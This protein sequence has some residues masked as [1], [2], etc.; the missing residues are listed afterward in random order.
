MRHQLDILGN[1]LDSLDEGLRQY[2]QAYA[3]GRRAYKFAVLLFAHF[4]E[5]LLKHAVAQ[6]HRLLIYKN[7]SA[8]KLEQEPTLGMWECLNILRNAGFKLEDKLVADLEWLKRLRNQIEHYSFDM[9]VREVRAA[10]GR[11]LRATVTFA[12]LMGVDPLERHLSD[13]GKRTFQRLLDEYQES[14]ANAEADAKE[15][16]GEKPVFDC[17]ICGLAYK[18]AVERYDGVYCHL[19][20]RTDEL[21]I[22]HIC[23]EWNRESY[24]YETED[25]WDL[26]VYECL[27]CSENPF[28]KP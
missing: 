1:A 19:C 15:E 24:M 26:D 22:C 2:E 28:A 23:D 3:G 21:Q 7:P 13:A 4:A 5:L 10:L 12:S 20:R 8:R 16:A 6:Q 9:D 11:A 27:D 14:I 18:T 25:E 17:G